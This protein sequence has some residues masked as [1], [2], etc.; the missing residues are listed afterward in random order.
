MTLPTVLAPLGGGSLAG[1]TCAG[2]VGAVAG[3]D[4]GAGGLG[5][6]LAGGVWAGRGGL[7]VLPVL[8]GLVAMRGRFAV[9][10]FSYSSAPCRPCAPW[11]YR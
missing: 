1:L 5:S 11:A 7:A 2:C 10:A 4:P 6:G 8:G 9:R 3:A